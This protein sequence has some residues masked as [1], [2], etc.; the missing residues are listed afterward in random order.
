VRYQLETDRENKIVTYESPIEFT[1]EGVKAVGPMP[2]QAEIGR[3][4]NLPSFHRGTRNAMRRAPKTIV[5]GEARDKETMDG[6]IE[7]SLT[8]HRVYSTV[9]ADTVKQTINRIISLFPYEAQPS[10][11]NKLAGALRMI[12]VQKLAHTLDGKR[13]AIREWLVFTPE[14]RRMLETLTLEQFAAYIGEEVIARGQSM[15]QQALPWLDRGV[16]DEDTFWNITST[17]V[18]DARKMPPPAMDD[19]ELEAEEMEAV[20]A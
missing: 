10:A 9:H 7:S 6:I 8:G 3:G 5:L 17:R 19:G 2:H 11:A 14:I 12:V 4:K 16:I 18:E 15:A 1:Y 13:Q 20:P